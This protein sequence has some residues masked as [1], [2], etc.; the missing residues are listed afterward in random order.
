M[1]NLET[2]LLIDAREASRRLAISRA[3]FYRLVKAGRISQGLKFGDAIQ[4]SRRWRLD[5]ILAFMAG[6]EV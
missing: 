5:D 2:Q 3:T 6:G 1:Q 4:A